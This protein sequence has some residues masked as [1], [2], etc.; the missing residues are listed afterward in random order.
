MRRTS[1]VPIPGVQQ[2]AQLALGEQFLSRVHATE[3]SIQVMSV[4]GMVSLLRPWSINTALSLPRSR[5]P[6]PDRMYGLGRREL[7]I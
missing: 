2:H 7:E 5:H 4:S 3:I 1:S 6:S